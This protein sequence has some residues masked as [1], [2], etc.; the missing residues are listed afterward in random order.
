MCSPFK[1]FKSAQFNSNANQMNTV[2]KQAKSNSA[3][4]QP[5]PFCHQQH[6][7]NSP[8]YFATRLSQNETSS[9]TFPKASNIACP[10]IEKKL[11]DTYFYVNDPYFKSVDS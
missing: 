11:D 6:Q 7:P 9:E 5:I 8:L 10:N 4:E 1:I 3:I 2:A